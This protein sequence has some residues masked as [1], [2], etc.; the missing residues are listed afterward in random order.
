MIQT[1][2]APP[3]M[4]RN[5]SMETDVSSKP[6]SLD[7]FLVKSAVVPVLLFNGCIQTTNSSL[8]GQWLKTA[9]NC[10][11]LCSACHL[12]QFNGPSKATNSIL[13]GQEL[14]IVMK[15]AQP[16]SACYGQESRHCYEIGWCPQGL[17]S[18]TLPFAG[19]VG[20][21]SS[22][23]PAIQRFQYTR[24]CGSRRRNYAV[25]SLICISGIFRITSTSDCVYKKWFKMEKLSRWNIS[26]ASVESSAVGSLLLLRSTFTVY[27]YL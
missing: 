16:C 5:T 21:G 14:N 8:E 13:G 12:T 10:Q 7:H 27:F 15:S 19:E 26:S 11:D 24:R 6:V 1:N 18:V 20:N 4:E 2:P 23:I 3:V 9:M 25:G 22:A 17:V